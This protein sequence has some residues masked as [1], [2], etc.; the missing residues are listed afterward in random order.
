MQQ[1]MTERKKNFS[2]YWYYVSQ[3][4][5]QIDFIVNHEDAR[6]YIL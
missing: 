6:G 2:W 1:W 3:N 4:S 5:S